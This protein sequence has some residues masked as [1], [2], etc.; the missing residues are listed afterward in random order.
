[1]GCECENS[2]CGFGGQA[3]SLLLRLPRTMSA[4]LSRMSGDNTEHDQIHPSPRLLTRTGRSLCATIGA[5]SPAHAPWPPPGGAVVWPSEPLNSSSQLNCSPLDE[6][7]DLDATK[8]HTIASPI[9]K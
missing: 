4:Y 6:G 3:G 5:L 7:H 2:C 1:M 9:P 8:P